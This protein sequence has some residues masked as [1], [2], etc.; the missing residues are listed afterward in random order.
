MKKLFFFLV[1]SSFLFASY[2]NIWSTLPSAPNQIRELDKI[3][4]NESFYQQFDIKKDGHLIVVPRFKIV[5][6][7][8]KTL[9][10]ADIDEMQK[11]K[12]DGYMSI[13]AKNKNGIIVLR[14][15]KPE[16]INLIVIGDTIIDAL[17]IA[18]KTNAE[19]NKTLLIATQKNQVESVSSLFKNMRENVKILN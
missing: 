9:E 10:Y 14:P 17:L 6:K 16:K 13:L 11:F 5:Q 1:L 19:A 4:L 2:E 3:G 7:N 15:R 8:D 18:Q 12:L